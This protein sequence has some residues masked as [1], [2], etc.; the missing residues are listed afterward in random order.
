MKAEIES[1]KKAQTE[2]K[3]KMKYIGSQTKNL[4]ISLTNRRQN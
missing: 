3:L 1:L 2:I 4:E